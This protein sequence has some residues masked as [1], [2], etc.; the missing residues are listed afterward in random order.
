MGMSLE[1]RS[2]S[3]PTLIEEGLLFSWLVK[4]DVLGKYAGQQVFQEKEWEPV[5]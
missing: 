4:S 2:T 1:H 5:I 3:Y